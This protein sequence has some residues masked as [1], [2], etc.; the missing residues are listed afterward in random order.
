M[1]GEPDEKKYSL[2]NIDMQ[3]VK[4]MQAP[5]S[6]FLSFLAIDRYNYPVT[7]STVFRIDN[8][9]LVITEAPTE[10]APEVSTGSDTA[11]ALKN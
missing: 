6:N 10:V 2:K 5:L 8:G 7:E 11:E 9:D 1:S 3:M 4:V